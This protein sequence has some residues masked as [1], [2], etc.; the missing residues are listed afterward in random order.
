MDSKDQYESRSVCKGF[1]QTVIYAWA[2]DA[3]KLVLPTDVAFKVGKHTNFKYL[4]LQV[5]YA[6]VEMFASKSCAFKT[7]QI[8]CFKRFIFWLRR[9]S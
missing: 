1:K 9:W 5:H 8:H 3:P 4:V 2:M 6:H 7:L